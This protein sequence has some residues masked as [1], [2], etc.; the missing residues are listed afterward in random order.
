MG[1]ESFD[2]KLQGPWFGFC[3]WEV[4]VSRG[5]KSSFLFIIRATVEAL[6]STKSQEY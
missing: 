6:C 4:T 1:R 3:L 5:S 2:K